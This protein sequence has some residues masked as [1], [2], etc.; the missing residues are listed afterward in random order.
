MLRVAFA[1]LFGS[2]L[3]ALLAADGRAS[4]HHPTDQTGTVPVGD[5]TSVITFGGEAEYVS[6]PVITV[7]PPVCKSLTATSAT[8]APPSKLE[9]G[10][11]ATIEFALQL[12][13]VAATPFTVTTFPARKP[14]PVIV[15]VPPP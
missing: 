14:V 1:G 8:N 3:A 6:A 10:T 4:L 11:T 9:A 2:L 12:V 15:T 5:E 7:L 13:T